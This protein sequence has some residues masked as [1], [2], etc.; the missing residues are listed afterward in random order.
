MVRNLWAITQALIILT[1]IEMV[2]SLIVKLILGPTYLDST[3]LNRSYQ[4]NK[5]L[6]V[7]WVILHAAS[8]RDFRLIFHNSDPTEIALFSPQNFSTK[9]KCEMG[10]FALATWQNLTGSCFFCEFT[11]ELKSGTKWVVLFQKT[12]SW[13]LNSVSPNFHAI[14]D[15][16]F[17]SPSPLD[18]WMTPLIA[19]NQTTENA[20]VPTDRVLLPLK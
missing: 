8:S 3:Y 1:T 19:F 18:L 16:S 12:T 5:P 13:Y 6:I 14:L 9:K 7:P 2:N 15:Y 4:L 10:G 20:F 11:P 17:N